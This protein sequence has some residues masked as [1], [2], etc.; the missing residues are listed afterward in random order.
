MALNV[1][2]NVYHSLSPALEAI[3]MGKIDDLNAKLDALDAALDQEKS[4]AGGLTAEIADLKAKL[5]S[6]LSADEAAAVEAKIDALLAKVP[7][8]VTPDAPPAA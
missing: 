6:G 7:G 4:E 2:V 8:T 1:N 5:A 3:V